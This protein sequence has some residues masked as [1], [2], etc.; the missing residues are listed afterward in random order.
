MSAS[1]SAIIPPVI[2]QDLVIFLNSLAIKDNTGSQ[3]KV[4]SLHLFGYVSLSFINYLW[5]KDFFLYFDMLFM[6]GTEYL[7]W[8]REKDD[9]YLFVQSSASP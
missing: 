5:G 3:D 6:G 8:I 1:S 4:Y 2:L 9:S 7:I